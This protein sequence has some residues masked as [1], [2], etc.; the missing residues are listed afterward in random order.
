MPH[1]P[2]VAQLDALGELLGGGLDPLDRHEVVEVRLDDLAAQL[3][4]DRQVGGELDARPRLDGSGVGSGRRAS[5]KTRSRCRDEL[6]LAHAKRRLGPAEE[7]LPA[8]P[9]L[10][11]GGLVSHVEREWYRRSAP[12]TRPSRAG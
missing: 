9:R 8:L 3:D 4:A 6:G 12:A 2:G 7:E 5:R 11:S 1:L 10:A